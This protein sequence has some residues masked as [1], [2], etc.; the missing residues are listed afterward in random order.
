MASSRHRSYAWAKRISA[1]GYPVKILYSRRDAFNNEN[2]IRKSFFIIKLVINSFF[3]ETI[4][5]HKYVPPKII[6]KIVHR[7]RI[8][9]DFDDRIY[10]T[11]K[12]RNKKSRFT[13]FLY[14][15]NKIIVS[16]DFLRSEILRCHSQLRK[17]ITVIPTLVDLDEYRCHCENKGKSGMDNIFRIGWIGTS[18]SFQYLKKIENSI[19]RLLNEFERQVIFEIVSDRSFQFSSDNCEV[20]NTKW[21]L[22]DEIRY[23]THFDITIMPLDDSNRARGKAAYKAIQSLAANVP[24]IASAVG[25]NVDIIKHGYNGYLAYDDEQFY[26]YLKKIIEDRSILETL[27]KNARSSVRHMDYSNWSNI[28]FNTIINDSEFK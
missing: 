7:S 9:F 5:F 24:V 27:R 1:K 14:R 2:A 4:I 17:K 10:T 6:Q 22:D 26:H 3:A 23:F 19:C 18:S 21:R 11:A 12:L 20:I 8:I 25:F 16:S 15:A 13:S 28:Y